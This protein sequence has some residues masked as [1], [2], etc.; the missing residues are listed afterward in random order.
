VR[1]ALGVLS[2]AA[3]CGR[4]TLGVVPGGE[5]TEGVVSDPAARSAPPGLGFGRRIAIEAERTVD[6]PMELVWRLLRDYRGPRARVLGEPFAEYELHDG[7]V[8]AGTVIG[9]RLRVGRNERSYVLAVEEPTPGRQLR[10][11][12]RHG[13][14]LVTWTLTPGGD[15]ERTLVRVA[16]ELR[17][18][19]LERVLTRGRARR[20][21]RRAHVHLL[22][23][24]DREL[25]G[26]P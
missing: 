22:E 4:I 8:G 18:P 5:T 17:D 21:L 6:A 20:A 3:A 26:N 9:Y 25:T 7:G 24:L 16:A 11:R 13:G 12:D 23:R 2:C 14:L 10:E 19:A 15:G 1:D